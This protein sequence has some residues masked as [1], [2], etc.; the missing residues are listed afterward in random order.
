MTFG[1]YVNEANGGLSLT[2]NVFFNSVRHGVLVQYSSNVNLT[3]NI[4]LGTKPRDG[5]HPRFEKSSNF[6]LCPAA[7]CDNLDVI[8]NVAAGG[9]LGFIAAA[10]ECSEYGSKS[11]SYFMNNVAHS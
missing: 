3:R 7:E 6:F 2:D 1:L 4:V 5:K 8:D 9:T 10:E 11:R